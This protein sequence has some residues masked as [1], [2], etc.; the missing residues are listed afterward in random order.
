[1]FN[2]MEEE[3]EESFFVHLIRSNECNQTLHD[4]SAMLTKPQNKEPG[5]KCA[6]KGGSHWHHWNQQNMLVFSPGLHYS[7]D[8][9]WTNV[10]YYSTCNI[11]C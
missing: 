3:R 10:N 7:L 1:M 4:K 8:I 9:I 5:F 11:M 2:M 6:L